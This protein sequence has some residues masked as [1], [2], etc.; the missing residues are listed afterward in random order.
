M[1]GIRFLILM[2]MITFFFGGMA[3]PAAVSAEESSSPPPS[4]GSQEKTSQEIQKITLKKCV[5]IALKNNQRRPASQFALAAAEAQHQ[6]ALSAF[7]PQISFRGSYTTLDDDPNFIFPATSIPVPSQTVTIPANAFAPGFP[8]APVRLQTPAGSVQVPEQDIKLMDKRNFITSLNVN[9]P[10][11]TGGLRLAKVKQAKNGMK[12]AQEEVRR[13]DLQVMYDVHRMY[14]G[15]LLAQ[16]LHQIGRDALARLAVTLELTE[17]LYKKGSGRVKKTDYLRNKSTVEGVRTLVAS[18][19]S[20]EQLA[21]AALL[22]TMGLDWDTKIEITESDLPYQPYRA[23]LAELIGQA[24]RFNPD[25]AK[26]KAGL[27]ASQAKITEARSGFFPK[28]LLTGTLNHIENRYDQG[29]VTPRNKDNYCV[30]LMFELPLFQGFLTLNKL[31]EARANFNKMEAEQIL[32]REGIALQVK[33]IF[34]KLNRTQDQYKA[35]KEAM[36]SATENRDLNERAYQAEMVETKDVLEA[37][38]ME[39]FMQAQHQKV[40]YD[41]LETKAHLNFVVGQEVIKF[42]EKDQGS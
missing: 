37:Q 22:N 36:E 31:K 30:G 15:V 3:F 32:L 9:Y 16:Q 41:H 34:H 18:L 40:L 28:I 29:I 11:F 12:V 14:Y 17:N 5:D 6:Q 19:K 23:N 10:L 26:L 13:T 24:Y 42:L 25:W 2:I 21:R 39:S 27:K 38:I 1:R 4:Q 20:N 33:D 8:R 7:W 35:S